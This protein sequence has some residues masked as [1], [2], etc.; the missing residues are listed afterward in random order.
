L[1]LALHI[2]G[3]PDLS[4]EA[5]S[6]ETRKFAARHWQSGGYYRMLSAMLFGASDPPLRYRMLQRF[7]ALRPGLIERF[8]A[9]GSSLPDKVRLLA[10]K[11]PVPITAAVAV[12]A[13]RRPLASLENPA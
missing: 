3:L 11:P 8:Y 1:R 13:G 10:G 12:L 6:A 7:Y 2:A 4:G 5:L 9:G